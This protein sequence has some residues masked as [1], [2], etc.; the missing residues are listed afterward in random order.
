M[1]GT[2]EQSSRLVRDARNLHQQGRL[3]DAASLYKKAL[4]ADPAHFD[5]RHLLGVLRHQQG[6][7]TEAVKLIAAALKIWP[8]APHAHSNY[9][10]CLHR[11]GRSAEAL[12]SCNRALAIDPNYAEAHN[13]RGTLLASLGRYQEALD[14][15]DHAIA[16]RPSYAEAFCN[17]G[18]A[19]RA[20][21]RHD[22]ALAAYREALNRDPGYVEAHLGR[23]DALCCLDRHREALADYDRA[24]ALAPRDASALNDRAVALAHLDRNEQALRDL[25]QALAIRPRFADAWN[26]RGN[27]QKKIGRYADAFASYDQALTIDPSHA[28][29]LN[30]RGNALCALERPDDA[31]ASYD[32][33]LKKKPDYVDALVNRGKLLAD[34]HRHAE[35][36]ALHERALAVA[37]DNSSAFEGL[38]NSALACCDWPRV[39]EIAAKLP[40]HIAARRHVFDPLLLMRYADDP[41]LLLRCAQDFAAAEA[42][43]P[44]MRTDHR[45]A[46]EKIRLGY[47]S[48]DFNNHAVASLVA[49]LF[50]IH[51]RSRFEVFG[52]SLGRD[53]GSAMRQRL[54]KAFDRFDD[55]RTRSDAEAA[56]L[57]D[58]LEIDIAVDL[59]GHT[60]GAR[61]G[62]LARRPAPIQVN[63]IGYP[64]TMGVDFVDYIVVDPIVVP[65]DQQPFF[66]ERLVHLPDCYQ[67]ND[68]KRPVAVRAPTRR[69]AGLPDEGFVFCCFNQTQKIMAPMF[70][71]WMRL[72]HGVPGSVLWLLRSNETVE[73]NLRREAAAR[74]VTPERVLFAGKVS[75][76]DHLARQR[77]A[78]LF[79]DTL[80]YNAHTT[81]SDALWV[82]LP[83]LTCRG[84]TFAARVA[85]SILHAAGV[86]D[87]VTDNL[88]DYEATALSLATDA[89]RLGSMRDKLQRQRSTCPLFDTD[90]FRRHIEAAYATM[91][92]RWRRGEAPAGLSIAPDGSVAP[93]SA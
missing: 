85:A 16:L 92:E 50:E 48:T 64:G 44:A 83:V 59:N 89:A 71:I 54:V 10:L 47:L 84:R 4:N 68:T 46:H 82:G 26:N 37:P 80:P 15:Y 30:N 11:L 31:L 81:A 58:R 74:G 14:S 17:R 34:L 23:A 40:D 19:E 25:D 12:E 45:G 90:R 7:D 52:F 32:R 69:E 20:L 56:E 39:A 75:P 13:N 76:P 22:D 8:D 79:L 93:V 43:R 9:A 24:L 53:D 3:D 33:A 36:V 6:R 66:T 38:A 67:V 65:P 1:V 60:R 70:D 55:L 18:D 78:D 5:A 86:P 77:L 51:D 29:A 2:A 73:A 57:I 21:G 42:A 87:L 61:P 49:E 88:A 62:I 63:F 27:V 72:L 91:Y 35:A 28:E 41:A